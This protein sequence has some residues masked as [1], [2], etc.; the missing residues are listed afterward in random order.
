MYNF[1]PAT[2]RPMPALAELR[3]RRDEI[4]AIAR[5][6]GAS[7]V[8]VFGSVARGDA[9]PDNDIDFLVDLESGR[10]LMD[11]AGLHLALE[12]LLGRSVDVGT[13]VKPRLRDRVETEVVAL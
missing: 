6:H 2:E 13:Q 7:N 10:S 5:S 3:E 1:E 11:L 12:D 4:L 8:R 9:R